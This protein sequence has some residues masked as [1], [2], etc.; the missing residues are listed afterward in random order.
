MG[1]AAGVFHQR[2]AVATVSGFAG[3]GFHAHIGGYP[4]QVQLLAAQRAQEAVDVGGGKGAD[5]GL[6]QHVF[7]RQGFELIQNLVLAAADKVAELGEQPAHVQRCV[8][9]VGVGCANG[10]VQHWAAQLLEVHA[11]AQRVGQHLL[12]DAGKAVVAHAG[13]LSLQFAR[14]RAL[15]RAGGVLHVDHHQRRA[16]QVDGALGHVG[17]DVVGGGGHGLSF[18]PA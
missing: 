15:A 6:A 11:Q 17:A 8:Q 18:W 13:A 10:H 16:R 12:L 1:G 2:H 7:A 5:G 3:G 14:Q 9:R 4:C